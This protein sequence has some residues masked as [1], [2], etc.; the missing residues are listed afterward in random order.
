MALSAWAVAHLANAAAIAVGA[1]VGEAPIVTRMFVNLLGMLEFAADARSG[2]GAP[3]P[4][5]I[6]G[7]GAAAEALGAG[8]S[9][10]MR[11][12][13]LR[14]VTRRR[15]A[16][17]LPDSWV[18][19]EEAPAPPLREAVLLAT[20][21]ACIA[22]AANLDALGRLEPAFL[23]GFS[24]GCMQLVVANALRRTALQVGASLDASS[25]AANVALSRALCAVAQLAGSAIS[26][27]PSAEVPDVAAEVAA[28]LA[29]IS[30]HLQRF[31]NGRAPHEL[32]DIVL[33]GVGT[34]SALVT[35]VQP[36]AVSHALFW[37]AGARAHRVRLDRGGHAARGPRAARRAAAHVFG[38]RVAVALL[39]LR[40]GGLRAGGRFGAARARRHGRARGAGRPARGARRR[41]ARRVR[42]GRGARAPTRPARAPRGW[43]RRRPRPRA[44]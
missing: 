13:R 15:A 21:N 40:A 42:G 18:A 20:A 38:G 9:L 24:R 11:E 8:L 43:T 31:G 33:A 10:L 5:V 37:R 39:G 34:S 3:A 22:L 30:A 17:P 14:A 28:A 29:I 41:A 35:A 6:A 2:R 27:V 19:A 26:R 16:L 25:P 12:P 36:I 1:F 4:L 32:R 7:A 44:G 23:E